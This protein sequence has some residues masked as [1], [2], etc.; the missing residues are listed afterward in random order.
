MSEQ[1]QWLV[2]K[3]QSSFVI[4]KNAQGGKV[5]TKEPNNLKNINSYK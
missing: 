5:F 3:K 2:I 1:L 4:R